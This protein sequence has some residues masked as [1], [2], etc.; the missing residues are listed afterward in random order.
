LRERAAGALG[1]R[2]DLRGFHDEVLRHGALPLGMLERV[3][4]EWIARVPT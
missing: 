2:F 3:I 4:D 1:A